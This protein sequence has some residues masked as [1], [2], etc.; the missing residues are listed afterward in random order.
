MTEILVMLKDGEDYPVD[1]NNF[2][3]FDGKLYVYDDDER[4]AIFNEGE[5]AFGV[6]TEPSIFPSLL[7]QAMSQEAN[8]KVMHTTVSKPSDSSCRAPQT[9]KYLVYIPTH[10]TLRD[11][12]EKLW[13]HNGKTWVRE[14]G[15]AASDGW[16]GPFTEVIE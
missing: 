15:R 5:W 12:D 11:G 6:K 7:M 10:L 2:D 13:Q 14:D 8:D 4:V 3:E 9:W 1:G 16:S